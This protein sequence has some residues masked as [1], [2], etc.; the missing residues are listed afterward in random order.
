[1]LTILMISSLFLVMSETTPFDE[2]VPG[3]SILAN[4]QRLGAYHVEYTRSEEIL[5]ISETSPTGEITIRQRPSPLVTLKTCSWKDDMQDVCFHYHEECPDQPSLDVKFD[6]QNFFRTTP[7][8]GCIQKPYRPAIGVDPD[9][10][11]SR[12]NAR[13]LD[14]KSTTRL[15]TPMDLLF[16][17]EGGPPRFLSPHVELGTNG[18]YP[19]TSVVRFIRT[20]SEPVDIQGVKTVQFDRETGSWSPKDPDK[21]RK[22]GIKGLK[23]DDWKFAKKRTMDRWWLDPDHGYLPVRVD[24]FDLKVGKYVAVRAE[25]QRFQLIAPDTWIPPRRPLT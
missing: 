15:L 5:V 1:M 3:K 10:L 21:Y 18:Q 17:W 24:F 9:S 22:L 14:R 23:P 20:A 2:T 7:R 6:G 11:S 25:V 16:P 13:D 19:G 8:N 12:R 4:V